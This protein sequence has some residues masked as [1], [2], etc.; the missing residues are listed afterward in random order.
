MFLLI[1]GGQTLAGVAAVMSLLFLLIP[2][3]Q[4]YAFYPLLLAF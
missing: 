3:Y 1:P 2:E 4:Q